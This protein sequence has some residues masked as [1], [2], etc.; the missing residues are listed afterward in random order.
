MMQRLG[1]S[2]MAHLPV[3][4]RILL[5]A[6]AA[7]TKELHG[8]F[9]AIASALENA[10]IPHALVHVPLDDLRA[11]WEGFGEWIM[12]GCPHELRIEMLRRMGKTNAQIEAARCEH[13]THWDAAVAFARES[14]E[15]ERTINCGV[16]H[17]LNVLP[18]L[19]MRSIATG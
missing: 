8:D 11:M 1:I 9:S 12:N 19:W 10:S 15:V 7:L 18:R 5:F 14:G 4:R 6:F 3:P 16:Q 2:S 13:E 17:S